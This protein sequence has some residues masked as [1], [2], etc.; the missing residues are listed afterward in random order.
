[1]E[2]VNPK[3]DPNSQHDWESLLVDY[4]T[5]A[6]PSNAAA[7]FESKLNQCRDRVSLADEYQRALGLLGIASATADPPTGHKD[8]F[9]ARLATLPQEHVSETGTASNGGSAF[10]RD[11]TGPLAIVP[12]PEEAPATVADLAA[13][14]QRRGRAG[15]IATVAGIAAAVILLVSLWGWVSARNNNNSLQA[16][17]DHSNSQI[18]QLTSDLERSNQTLAEAQKTLNI[19]PDFVPFVVSS[20]LPPPEASG[21][22]FVNP[23]TDDFYLLAEGLQPISPTEVYEMWWI[24]KDKSAPVPAGNLT[25]QANG[26][27]TNRTKTPQ[28][29]DNY[30]AVAVTREQAP[31]AQQPQGPIVI[32]GSLPPTP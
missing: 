29:P 9:L 28:A 13:Y 11:R 12:S 6:M 25:M 23:K 4:T 27:A 22:G 5:G 21:V 26:V 1:M 30:S 14:R 32:A 16:E 7:D 18:Q 24:P 3:P 15:L 2:S 20:D 8:R 31:G 19:P 10:T 17:L